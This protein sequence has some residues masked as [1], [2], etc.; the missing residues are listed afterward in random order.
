MKIYPTNIEYS[1]IVIAP[2]YIE[3]EKLYRSEE[4]KLIVE[5]IREYEAKVLF[6]PLW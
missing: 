6:E 1:P 3:T 4:D 5:E 2:N